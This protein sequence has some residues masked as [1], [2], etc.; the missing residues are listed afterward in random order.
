MTR[1]ILVPL[2]DSAPAWNALEYTLSTYPEASLTAL[3]VLDPARH[4]SYG[5]DVSM[6]FSGEELLGRR[7]YEQASELLAEAAEW[8]ETEG[9]EVDTEIEEG[10]PAAVIVSYAEEHG[11]DQIVMGSHGRTGVKRLLLG[12]VAE[13]VVRR[14]PVP[15]T[16]VREF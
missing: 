2:D 12:S 9:R 6:A 13:A 15:V 5:G 16:V 10:Y 3:H 4:R 7:Q 14:S 8:A 11:I 1:K